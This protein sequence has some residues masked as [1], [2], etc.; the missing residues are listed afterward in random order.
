MKAQSKFPKLSCDTFE[1][2]H[3]LSRPMAWLVKRKDDAFCN[4]SKQLTLST[5]R[6]CV[7]WKRTPKYM[8]RYLVQTIDGVRSL[9]KIYLGWRKQLSNLESQ[10][11]YIK[12]DPT[13][14]WDLPGSTTLSHRVRW[15]IFA[16]KQLVKSEFGV[17]IKETHK[18]AHRL[19]NGLRQLLTAP[20]TL[21]KSWRDGLEPTWSWRWMDTW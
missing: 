1:I 8:Y 2:K 4:E 16:F 15:S 9:L 6:L 5:S 19:Y 18:V 17:E 7:R 10:D 21:F 12:V 14:L 11:W 13:W 20:K 3:V